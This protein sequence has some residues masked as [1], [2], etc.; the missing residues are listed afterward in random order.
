MPPVEIYRRQLGHDCTRMHGDLVV[1]HRVGHGRAHRARPGGA[2]GRHVLGEVV[3]LGVAG[4]AVDVGDLR[5]NA[6]ADGGRAVILQ[7]ADLD[8]GGAACGGVLKE[9]A[10]GIHVAAGFEPRRYG[11]RL[12]RATGHGDRERRATGSGAIGRQRRCGDG[13]QGNRE[14][15]AAGAIAVDGA[16]LR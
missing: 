4:G 1:D 10:G 9:A 12:G 7:Q 3:Q 5:G 8:I 16:S 6:R 13:R 14:I 11:A 2:A 15:G